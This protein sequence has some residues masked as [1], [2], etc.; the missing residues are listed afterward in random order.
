LI[1]PYIIKPCGELSGQRHRGLRLFAGSDDSEEWKTQKQSRNS[2]PLPSNFPE[3]LIYSEIMFMQLNLIRRMH[4]VLL[5]CKI[6][7]LISAD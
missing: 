1:Q 2:K 6:Q 4:S 5:S 7:G 3:L